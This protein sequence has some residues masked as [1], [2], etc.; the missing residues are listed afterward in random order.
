MVLTLI[1]IAFSLFNQL[2]RI[3]P[4]H[5]FQ[6]QTM[7]I[8]TTMK[9]ILI[10]VGVLVA[11]VT[12]LTFGQTTEGVI[13]YEVKINMHRTLPPDRQEMKSM[14]PE[15]RTMQDQLVFNA[16]ESLYKPV[17]EEED[18]FVN[19]N[20]GMRMQFR[21]PMSEIYLDVANQRRVAQ[22]EFFG[23]QYL[24]EDTVKVQP[25]KFGTATKTVMGYECRQASVYNEERKQNIVAWFTDKLR[26][27]LG[28]ETYGTL[29]GAVLQVDFNDGE[30]TLTAK[31]IEP[32]ALRKGELKIPNSGTR[33]T[34]EAF[35]KMVQEQSQRMG[36][37]GG[38]IIIRS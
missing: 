31:K 30:R 17:E 35:R 21:R 8:S 5:L 26:T 24:I 37:S 19:E 15:F 16:T 28:P 7:Q 10:I 27:G 14:M 23:K 13:L 36:G 6:K 33:T 18:D 4:V 32:R 12:S 11:L 3:A 34:E 20:G 1:N 38:N 9:R 2:P 22:R 25:W 29:P